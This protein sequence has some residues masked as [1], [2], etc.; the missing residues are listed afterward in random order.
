MPKVLSKEERA[1]FIH[2]IMPFAIET[3]KA[4]KVP[5]S[6]TIAQAILE[7]GW[8][9]RAPGNNFFGVKAV[10]LV[11]KG[12]RRMIMAGTY[13]SG[14]TPIPGD[15]QVLR[16]KEV[17]NH[18]MVRIWDVFAKYPTPKESFDARARLF[19]TCRRYAKA[20]QTNDGIG[21]A[22]AIADAGYSTSPDYF[23]TLSDIIRQ[24]NLLQ[25]DTV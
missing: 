10:G 25:Y 9:V 11:A 2:S 3:M 22:R 24:N 23:D 5:A 13:R 17:I 8:G 7:S 16:T 6:V 21:F 14:V 1:A 20:F 12:L 19:T 15:M 18:V 4:S